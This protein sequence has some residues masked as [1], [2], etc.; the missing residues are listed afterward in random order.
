MPGGPAPWLGPPAPRRSASGVPA[1]VAAP[2]VNSRSFDT[3]PAR[4]ATSPSSA[5]AART[6]SGPDEPPTPST[7]RPCST[8][9]AARERAA[10]LEQDERH[11]LL[12]A[13]APVAVLAE[14]QRHGAHLVGGAHVDAIH[15]AMGRHR[16]QVDD[17]G[18]EHDRHRRARQRAHQRAE[19]ADAALSRLRARGTRAQVVVGEIARRDERQAVAGRP[20]DE[21]ER[22]A[23]AS[24]RATRTDGII[25]A[26]AVGSDRSRKTRP[27]SSPQRSMLTV[28][29]SMPMTRGMAAS[30]G[31]RP[32]PVS[33]ADEATSRNR[34]PRRAQIV[35]LEQAG[36]AGLVDLHL[37]LADAERAERR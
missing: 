4:N 21:I 36:D 14:R 35:A 34:S 18:R 7:M 3:G 25:S 29:G 17:A 27:S 32:H 15:L 16:R 9:S 8:A 33:R 23:A 10:Q 26:S 2:P 22:C 24:S 11:V 5:P 6:P 20:G 1:I 30:T 19:S 37:E 13:C 12:A 31:G 28:P